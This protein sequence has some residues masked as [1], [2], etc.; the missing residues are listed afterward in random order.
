MLA[1]A[2]YRSIDDMDNLQHPV[3]V[4]Q[5]CPR[6]MEVLRQKKVISKVEPVAAAGFENHSARVAG[7]KLSL[8]AKVISV[9]AAAAYDQ[10]VTLSTGAVQVYETDD[11]DVSNTVLRGVGKECRKV[12]SGHLKQRRWVFVAAKAI[13]AYDYN[14]TFERVASGS[15]V[16]KCGIL[17]RWFGGEGEISGKMT[18]KTKGA[19]SKTFV[20]VA[21][22][23]AEIEIGRQA[24]T[25]ADVQAL[26]PS[27]TRRVA[28][29]ARTAA[30][31][32]RAIRVASARR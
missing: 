2:L 6:D 26:S 25:I 31:Q 15:G 32:G 29:S 1:P 11:D 7:G 5:I 22:V 24:I 23:P 10:L 16:V 8:D 9:N 3:G 18:D 20:T 27:T 4:V 21:L 30:L 17:C 28:R 12:I 14:A 13:Q 19:A